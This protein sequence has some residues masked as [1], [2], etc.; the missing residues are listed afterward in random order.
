MN[1][2]R[3]NPGI[4]DMVSLSPSP[5]P[6]ADEAE[7]E[8]HYWGEHLF[9]GWQTH[10]QLFRGRRAVGITTPSFSD[11]LEYTDVSDLRSWMEPDAAPLLLH[12]RILSEHCY[13]VGPSGSGKTSLGIMPS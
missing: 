2:V 6:D 11:S 7:K 1:F 5:G 4:G 8:P 13:I 9:V 10:K 3:N 12:E